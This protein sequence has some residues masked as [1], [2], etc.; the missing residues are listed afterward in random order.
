MNWMSC[1]TLNRQ[2]VVFVFAMLVL[3]VVVVYLD[4]GVCLIGLHLL[5]FKDFVFG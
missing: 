3:R 2:Q 4:H 1:S 5:L